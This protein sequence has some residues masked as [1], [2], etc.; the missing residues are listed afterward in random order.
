[1]SDRKSGWRQKLIAFSGSCLV[2]IV[3]L[4]VG[5]VYCRWFTNINFLDHSSGLFTP[6]RFGKT[7][8]NTPNFRGISFGEAVQTDENGFRIDPDF[9]PA[10][11][12][13]APAIMITGDSVSFG[14]GIRDDLT[15]AGRLRRYMPKEQIYNASVIGYDAPAYRDSLASLVPQMRNVK[16]VLLFY[17]LN[18][19]N[20]VSAGEIEA[21]LDGESNTDSTPD[22][23]LLRAVND[24]LRSR[25][26]L[27]LW[28]KSA[29]RDTQL[30]HFKFDLVP[31][32][33]G[34]DYIENGLRP[35][36]EIKAQLEAEGVALKIFVLP[37]EAQVRKTPPA[38][39]LLPQQKVD[40]FLQKNHFEFY[41]LLSDFRSVSD[42]HSLFLYGDP[43]HLSKMGH[44]LAAAK[45]CSTLPDCHP[46]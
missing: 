13:D 34:D 22:W 42:P 24:Y 29:M 12:S 17:C 21:R 35:L 11:L 46:Q 4:A 28:L 41:D 8:A 5:E 6:G 43:M 33:Q 36:K 18:D 10:A 30:D 23:S 15:I 25:S 31:Y 16:T 32:K 3:L 45:V 44:E 38:D 19:L 27:Y 14:T 7:F 37:Y 1:M 9:R 20:D 40:A 26:K 39:Y 2:V